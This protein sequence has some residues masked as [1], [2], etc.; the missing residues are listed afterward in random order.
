[1]FRFL[2]D[3]GMNKKSSAILV[4]GANRGQSM[5][6]ILIEAPY[7]TLYGFETRTGRRE[8]VRVTRHF[9]NAVVHSQGWGEKTEKNIPIGGMEV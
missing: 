5:R 4:A 2:K 8:A 1:M 9:E 7:V 3:D 6:N